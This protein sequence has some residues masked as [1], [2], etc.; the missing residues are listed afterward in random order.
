MSAYFWSSGRDPFACENL[1]APVLPHRGL[2]LIEVVLIVAILG[3][4]ALV[5]LPSLY[6]PMTRAARLSCVSHLKQVSLAFR[7]YA[8][9]WQNRFPVVST[10]G[11]HSGPGWEREYVGRLRR[12]SNELVVPKLLVCPNDRRAPASGFG[13][14]A[15]SN[16]SYFLNAD[17][18]ERGEV[19]LAG[20]RHLSANGLPVPSGVLTLG[21]NPVLGWTPELHRGNGN[22]A[23][24][25]GSVQGFADPLRLNEALR[26]AA[27]GA[28]RIFV[29]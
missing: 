10:N 28:H 24:G 5:I 9:D 12:L 19:V 4:L 23:F 14:L 11:W 6:R 15:V 29:P 16:L 13:A 20:D 7:L 18:V 2:T 22:V 25:D 1:L 8:N 26:P 27:L 21:T 3:I 17:G